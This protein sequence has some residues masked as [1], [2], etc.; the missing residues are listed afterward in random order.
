MNSLKPLQ[1]LAIIFG[2]CALVV[3]LG[4]VLPAMVS[5]TSTTI[6]GAGI[7]LTAITVVFIGYYGYQG[8]KRIVK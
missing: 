2:V 5:A 4:V 6:A 8:I 3:L 1:L 7:F